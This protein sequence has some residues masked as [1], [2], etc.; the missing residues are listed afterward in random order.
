MSYD[1]PIKPIL[2]SDYFTAREYGQIYD[3]VVK[4][5]QRGIDEANDKYAYMLN[6]TNNGF[7]AI[8]EDEKVRFPESVRNKVKQR[9]TDLCDEEVED[10]GIMFARYTLDS[11]LPTLMPHC[12][13]AMPKIAITATIPLNQTKQWDFY[14]NDEKFEV[15]V[16]DAVWFSGNH[17]VHWRPDANFAPEDYYDIFL[18]QSFPKNDEPRLP[19]SHYEE[20]DQEAGKYMQKYKDLLTESLLKVYDPDGCQ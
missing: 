11:A 13:R 5:M 20:R 6:L 8:F 4:V 12:D 14:V 17:H 18:V 7:M 15:G 10:V 16:N 3:V 19:E 2:E 1:T 9:M